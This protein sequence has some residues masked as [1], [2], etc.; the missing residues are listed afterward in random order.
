MDIFLVRHGEAAASWGQAADPGLSELGAEQAQTAAQALHDRLAADVQ[1][2]SSP[3]ARARETAEPL[4]S[5]LQLP[6]HINDAFREIAAPVPL[7]ERQA[8]LRQFMQQRWDEQ[9]DSLHQWR[10]QA[11]TQLLELQRPTVVYTHFLVINAVVGQILEAANTL[12]FWPENASITHLR[13]IG[14]SLELVELGA[15]MPTVVD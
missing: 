7:S 10:Q 15:Q 4:A 12:H 3:L 14:H 5:A 2:V 11:L 6:V 1:L 13:S 8:W 9:P